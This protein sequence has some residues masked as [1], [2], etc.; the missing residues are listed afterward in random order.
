MYAS[1]CEKFYCRGQVWERDEK[2]ERKY[3]FEQW[4]IPGEIYAQFASSPL[5]ESFMWEV[6]LKSFRVESDCEVR[7]N[8]FQW[9]RSVKTYYSEEYCE[10][11]CACQNKKY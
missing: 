5:S 2:W 10:L 7:G 1:R 3:F 6:F 11:K 9:E 8:K 4:E